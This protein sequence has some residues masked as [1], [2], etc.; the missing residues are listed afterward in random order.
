MTEHTDPLTWCIAEGRAT[1]DVGERHRTV[2]T[3]IQR[4]RGVIAREEHTVARDVGD[5]LEHIRRRVER[6]AHEHDITGTRRRAR[7]EYEDPVP[8]PQRRLHAVA[9]HGHAPGP[10]FFFVPQHKSLI[11]LLAPLNTAV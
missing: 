10:A 8:L 6:V 2:V 3:A 7:R 9:A 11:Y 4:V 1:D 5:A